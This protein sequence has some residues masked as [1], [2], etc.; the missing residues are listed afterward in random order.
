MNN[1]SRDQPPEHSATP[2]EIRLLKAINL[3][4]FNALKKLVE[5]T[6]NLLDDEV[7]PATPIDR[8]KVQNALKDA[9]TVLE[10]IEEIARQLK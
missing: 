4:L 7:V 2:E 5:T 10:Q 3:A 6:E 1:I 8:A 9:R